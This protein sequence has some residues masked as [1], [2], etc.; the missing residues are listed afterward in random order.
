M[1]DRGTEIINKR[2]D[3]KNLQDQAIAKQRDLKYLNERIEKER[4]ELQYLEMK[5]KVDRA[6]DDLVNYPPDF[7]D[8]L[9]TSSI[10]KLKVLYY[11]M[12]DQEINMLF[13]RIH[14]MK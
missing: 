1:P 10:E 9:K 14:S 12:S 7:K 2:M 6:I 11:D 4:K 13:D 3:L 5:L 8:N